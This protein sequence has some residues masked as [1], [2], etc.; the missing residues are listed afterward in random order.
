ML[1]EICKYDNLGTPDYFNDALQLLRKPDTSWTEVTLS[2]YFSNKVYKG[3]QYIDGG[4]PFLRL[5]GVIEEQGANIRIASNNGSL[6][7]S[8]AGIT[9]LIGL[10]LLSALD[11]KGELLR[12]FDPQSITIDNSSGELV[13]GPQSFPLRYRAIRRLLV[14]LDILSRHGASFSY[15]LKPPF[16]QILRNKLSDIGSIRGL[17]IERL[18]EALLRQ[19]ILGAEAEEFVLQ[20]ELKRLKNHPCKEQIKRISEIDVA[21]GYDI[22]SFNEI[23]SEVPDRFVEVKSFVGTPSFYWTKNEL[24]TAKA[25]SGSYFLYLVDRDGC[26]TAGYEPIIVQDPFSMVY[27]SQEWVKS[28]TVLYVSKL[29]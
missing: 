27:E 28:P 12:L 16:D 18:K 7:T 10:K 15:T 9:E 2:H 5:V 3:Y 6:P 4:V 19:E 11:D 26:S 8:P 25:K 21:A 29:D 17:S 13:I 14:D 1:D 24:D 22:V 20:Y 23:K